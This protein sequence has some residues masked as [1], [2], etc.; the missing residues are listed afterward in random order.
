VIIA[1]PTLEFFVETFLLVLNNLWVMIKLLP[2]GFLALTSMP[3]Q[4]SVR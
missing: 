2:S 3:L 1:A 4:Q